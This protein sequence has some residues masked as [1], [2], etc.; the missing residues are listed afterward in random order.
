MQNRLP[1]LHTQKR[2]GTD[3]VDFDQHVLKL[4]II[5]DRSFATA[6]DKSFSMS[7]VI[8]IVNRNYQT[9]FNCLLVRRKQQQ[10][11]N[12]MVQVSSIL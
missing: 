7:M 10:D 3:H 1:I 6:R 2:L 9:V 8:I 12:V 11:C 5:Y 4:T